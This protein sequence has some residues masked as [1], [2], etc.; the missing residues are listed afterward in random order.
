MH[1]IGVALILTALA[2]SDVVAPSTTR[3]VDCEPVDAMVIK[4]IPLTYARADE[5][6]YTL[7]LVAPG[8]VRIVPYYPTNSVIISGPRTVVE[9]L[10]DIIK[11]S[12]GDADRNTD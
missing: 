6:A 7:S 1:A 12:K 5:L 11:P 10:S 2:S 9:Q 4:V 8:P 3:S